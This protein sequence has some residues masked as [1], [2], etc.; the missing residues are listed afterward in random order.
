[1][2][3]LKQPA[4]AQ[5]IAIIGL[6]C[7]FP[8]APDADTYWRLLRDGVESIT[9]FNDRELLDS[10]ISPELVNSPDYVRARA[11]IEGVESMDAAFFGFTPREAE[12]MDPQHRALLECA[13]QALE[14]AGYGGELTGTAVGVFAGASA[15]SYLLSSLMAQ[16][17][18]GLPDDFQLLMGNSQDLLT[19]RVSYKLDLNGPSFTVQT[20]CSTSLV[21]IHLACQSLLNGECDMALA[22]GVSITVPA[23]IGYVY[24]QGGILSPDGHCRTFDSEA[25]GTVPGNGVGL[26]VLKRLEDALRDRDCIRCV[27]KGSAINNDGARKAGFTAPS[28]D[29][30]AAVIAEALSIAGAEPESITMV[31]CHGTATQLGDPIEMQALREAF[32]RGPGKQYCAVGSVKSNMGHL[33]AA[34]G[35]A[36]FIKAVLS[37]QNRTLP[38]SLHFTAPNP[39]IDFSNSPFYVNTSTRE[40]GTERLPR[41]AGVSSFGIGGTNAHVVLEE[42]PRV[43]SNDR[44]VSPQLLVLSARTPTALEAAT[45]ELAGHLR[46]H[47]ELSLPDVAFTLQTGRR[48][49]EDRRCI[50]ASSTTEAAEALEKRSSARV[51]SGART[52]GQRS[53]CFLFPGQGSQYVGMAAGIYETQ[54]R[55]RAV[56]DRLSE[57]LEKTIGINLRH[58]LYSR[59]GD[60]SA[61]DAL[62]QT[63][64][65]QPAL[66]VIEYALARLW[67]DWGIQPEAMIGHSVGEYVAA[68]LAGVFS[69]EDALRLVAFRGSMMQ[70][71]P[72]G[73]MLAVAL[74]EKEL[75]ARLSPELSIAAINAPALC[76]ASGPMASITALQEKLLKEGVTCSRLHTSHAFHSA[77]MEPILDHF[78]IEV[79]RTPKS[80]P[81]FRWFSNVT[82]DWI[83]E[84]DALSADY[85]TRHIRECVRFSDSLRK[86]LGQQGLIWLEV[87][88]GQSLC[89]L[90]KQDPEWTTAQ[91]VVHSIRHFKNNE[92]D[93][94]TTLL[95]ALGRLWTA[96]IPVA[97]NA[98]SD[99]ADHKVPLP[100]YPFERRR[101]WIFDQLQPGA[102]HTTA[103]RAQ[104][105]APEIYAPIWKQ[106]Q[107]GEAVQMPEA[108]QPMQW[109]IFGDNEAGNTASHADFVSLF[110]TALK[111][112]GHTV[113][114]VA[115]GDSWARRDSGQYVV[116]PQ[117]K[118]DF[119][120][121]AKELR[122]QGSIPAKWLYLAPLKAGSSGSDPILSFTGLLN[123]VQ[124][125]APAA[126]NNPVTTFV[127]TP[128]ILPIVGSE[129]ADPVLATSIGL[130]R[131]APSEYGNLSCRIVDV[132]TT[133]SPDVIVRNVLAEC[134]IESAQRVIALRGRKRWIQGFEQIESPPK[135]PCIPLREEGVYLIT[136]A[137]SPT[138]VVLARFLHQRWKAKLVLLASPGTRAPGSEEDAS[139][140]PAFDALEAWR[141]LQSAGAEIIFAPVDLVDAQQVESIIA[142]VRSRFGT[143]HGVLQIENNLAG[144]L[145]AFKS[146]AAFEQT[147][148]RRINALRVLSA[149]VREIALDFFAM[150]SSSIAFTGGIGQADTCSLASFLDSF[151]E[152]NRAQDRPFYS[153]AWDAFEWE[154]PQM[155]E[156][157]AQVQAQL[158]SNLAAFGLSERHVT[159]TLEKVLGLRM[160]RSVVSRRDFPTIFRQTESAAASDVIGEL[161]KLAGRPAG[162]SH[163]RPEM[164]IPYAA[165]SS[166]VERKIAAVWEEIFGIQGIGVND[167]FFALG[168]NSLLAIQLITRLRNSLDV[169][170]SMSSLFEQ[171]TVAGLAATIASSRLQQEEVEEVER[172]Y[173]DL[174]NLSE[175]ELD[176]LLRTDLS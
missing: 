117:R 89:G 140:A 64:I 141:A 92:E 7:R 43:E 119:D 87:G 108:Q 17:A 97:W 8:G 111:Q 90:V 132:Q 131:V 67:M 29:G 149:A 113:V 112:A 159:E 47:P 20:A 42:A 129:A 61:A 76:V 79:E 124:S 49:F 54:P 164:E 133:D 106:S 158:N 170:V 122:A 109:L 85:W 84:A 83:T 69:P 146:A 169:E 18:A 65:T 101:F 128:G 130:C 53:V 100:T 6:S 21:A 56:F 82:G 103:P 38:P 166:D 72:P 39:Q 80:A 73:S 2:D 86:L 78:R 10:G 41:R 163:G 71:L 143:I 30:Q 14:D 120:A 75:S 139:A 63:R 28:I 81:R 174:E 161:E 25:R 4:A 157:M 68:A 176:E 168:G 172:I 102:S 147:V 118:E 62:M 107:L 104:S 167:T 58:L 5:G 144:G 162:A 121:L 24:Q 98:V 9:F 74:P 154:Q 110:A 145:I 27:V 19:T 60:A 59:H 165:P 93:D 12:L 51:F 171:P 11:V 36:G 13:W 91:P 16:A 137:E 26:V 148:G 37:L 115:T 22:G 40:W 88:P 150:F 142:Q 77:M 127:I 48:T 94:S 156:A 136:A 138:G 96:G 105:T 46:L 116:S 175:E 151:A 33:D 15:N 135:R 160:A 52:P 23:H 95:T 125:L 1:M 44:R 70:E 155:P 45:T 35:V 34:A 3:E 134:G 57:L 173:K 114:T 126:G 152:A 32:G 99:G 50:V 123:L 55:F 66:F 153:I 31:E